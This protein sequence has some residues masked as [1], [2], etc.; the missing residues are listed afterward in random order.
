M[1]D[2]PQKRGRP[3]KTAPAIP[4]E[5]SNFDKLPDAAHVRLP[6]VAA[7]YACSSATVWRN[8]KSGRIPAP[9]KLTDNISAWRVG[10]L[11]AALGRGKP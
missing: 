4:P 9:V 8:V 3:R 10:E 7:L 2:S 1:T 5:L 6:T 11:R